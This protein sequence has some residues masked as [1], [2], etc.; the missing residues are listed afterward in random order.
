MFTETD[1]A[2]MRATQDL[3]MQDRCKILVYAAGTVDDYGE[4]SSP[5]YTAGSEISCGL[6]MRPGSE[7]HGQSLTTIT[8]DATLR[9]PIDTALKETDRITITKRYDE[10]TT[11]LTYEIASPPQRGASG[12]R[13]LLKK[14]TV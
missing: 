11:D 1:L 12:L 2:N 4:P 14:A 9:L 8:Y 13:V 7:R 3:Y 6:D 10:D 5:T